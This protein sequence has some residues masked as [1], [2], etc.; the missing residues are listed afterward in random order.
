MELSAVE[1][2]IYGPAHAV[3]G[4]SHG[5]H[6]SEQMP[7]AIRPLGE[8]L[9]GPAHAVKGL[10]HGKHASEQMQPYIRPLGEDLPESSGPDEICASSPDHDRGLRGPVPTRRPIF[11]IINR[12]ELNCSLTFAVAIF[13]CLSLPAG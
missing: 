9:Y 1:R 13:F 5:K 4:L 3:K 10:S 11:L 2:Y 7:P 12:V 8:D 6:A